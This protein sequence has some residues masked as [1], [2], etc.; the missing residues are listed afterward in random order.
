MI[1]SISY[2]QARLSPLAP[3]LNANVDVTGVTVSASTVSNNSQPW[4][5]FRT[6]GPD[7]TQG[8]EYC[9]AASVY[10]S[11]T[12]VYTGS[13]TT[14]ITASGASIAGEWVCSSPRPSR[15]ATS[16]SLSLPSTR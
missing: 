5:L 10:N 7:D 4:Y 1:S 13:V 3:S 15:S 6:K 16:P 12:G 14:P 9:S 11:T 8:Y 2:Q